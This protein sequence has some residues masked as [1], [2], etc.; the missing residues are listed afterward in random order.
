M[1]TYVILHKIDNKIASE[2]IKKLDERIPIE[3]MQNEKKLEDI[4]LVIGKNYK[5][6]NFYNRKQ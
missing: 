1:K 4:T 3:I 5:N 6:L 2:L